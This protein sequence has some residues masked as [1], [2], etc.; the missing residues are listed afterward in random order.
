MKEQ[1]GPAISSTNEKT[2]FIDAAASAGSAFTSSFHQYMRMNAAT[3]WP[4]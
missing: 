3:C 1:V 4:E 2:L